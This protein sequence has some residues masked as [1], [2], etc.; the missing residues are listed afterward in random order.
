MAYPGL[1]T[2]QCQTANGATWLQVTPTP[3]DTRPLVTQQLGP[4]WGLHL[5]DVNIAYDDLTNLV[6]DQ[7]KGYTG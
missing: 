2:G 6:N 7:L 3:G 4:T 1:Y 5:V